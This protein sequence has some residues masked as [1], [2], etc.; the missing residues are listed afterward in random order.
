MAC[1]GKTSLVG[2][3]AVQQKPGRTWLSSGGC[4]LCALKL[5]H[6]HTVEGL[7]RNPESQLGNMTLAGLKPAIFGSEDQRLIH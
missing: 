4:V 7:F 2:R 3:L 1:V 6:L 5:R